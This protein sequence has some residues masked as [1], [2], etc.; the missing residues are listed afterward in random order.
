[1]IQRLCRSLGER[2]NYGQ[3]ITEVHVL[4]TISTMVMTRPDTNVSHGTSEK[5][6][7]PLFVLPKEENTDYCVPLLV[8]VYILDGQWNT[9]SMSVLISIVHY[10]LFHT[11]RALRFYLYTGTSHISV[12]RPS[13]T[14]H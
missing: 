6:F 10:K 4:V 5:Q 13:Q 11:V 9:C 7:P 14:A 3:S 2:D 8:Y 1:M 12:G